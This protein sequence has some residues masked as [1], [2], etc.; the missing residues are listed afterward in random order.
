MPY[1]VVR[2]GGEFGI[3]SPWPPWPI[4]RSKV[5]RSLPAKPGLGLPL[6][7]IKVKKGDLASALT[8]NTDT[9]K[10]QVCGRSVN[11]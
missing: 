10:K 1:S 8:R 2:E 7:K 5:S 6:R 3:N 9:C 4:P 11:T